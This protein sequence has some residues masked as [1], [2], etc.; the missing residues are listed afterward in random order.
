MLKRNP[1]SMLLAGAL[2]LGLGGGSLDEARA[3]IKLPT[4]P[5]ATFSREEG[6]S[7]TAVAVAGRYA[8]LTNACGV[9]CYGPLDVI[10]ISTPSQPRLVGTTELSWGTAGI[11]VQGSF[12]YTTGYLANPNFLRAIDVS[13]P[14]RPYTAAAFTLAGVHPQAVAVDGPMAYMV[15]YGSDQLEVIDVSAPNASAFSPE[16]NTSPISLPFVGGTP[17]GAGPSSIAVRAGYAY[18]VNA[19]EGSV[20]VIDL[21]DPALPVPIGQ[22]SLGAP[23]T[24]DSSYAGIA[25]Q[26]SYAYVADANANALRVIDVSNP[27]TPSVVAT[28]AAGANPVAVA[29]EGGY[30]FVVNEASDTLQAFDVGV[31]TQPTSLGTIATG[32]RP[33]A[34]ALAG[35]YAYV[36]SFGG[37]SLQI[38]DLDAGTASPAPAD[39][40]APAESPAPAAGA[41]FLEA[42]ATLKVTRTGVVR[43]RVSCAGTGRCVGTAVLSATTGSR[44]RLGSA[45]FSVPEGRART[46]AMRLNRAGRARVRSSRRA[47]R[48]RLTLD[49][50]ASG[51]AL[52]RSKVVRLGRPRAR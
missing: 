43:F 2:A 4:Q 25:V 39:P 33:N 47:V 7:P 16:M 35:R 10:D 50:T 23:G 37:R 42:G 49:G 51:H 44:A 27:R 24:R 8:Y 19:V 28:I 52:R 41:F 18:V 9:G 6:G 30:A 3:A 15:D 48:A 34:V 1:L 38:F 17:T 21:A 29:A 5:V 40:P 46:V 45:R 36:S 11:A 32:S 20:Q 12:A 13:D 22:V 26:G 14:T 31:P